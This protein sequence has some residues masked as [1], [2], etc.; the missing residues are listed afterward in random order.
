MKKDPVNFSQPSQQQLNDLLKYYQTKQFDNA[1]KLA[2]SITK[3]FPKHPFGKFLPQ[4]S[5]KMER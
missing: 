4:H 5:N 2:A 3:E 1:E